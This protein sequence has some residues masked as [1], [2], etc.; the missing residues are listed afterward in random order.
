MACVC[1]CFFNFPL[2]PM[3]ET[4]LP[5]TKGP[6]S[7][8]RAECVGVGSGG[9]DRLLRRFARA[10]F[11]LSRQNFPKN[12]TL[13]Y[14]AKQGGFFVI[15]ISWFGFTVRIAVNLYVYTMRSRVHYRRRVVKWIGECRSFFFSSK[16]LFCL[17]IL[18]RKYT[19][20]LYDSSP[21]GSMLISYWERACDHS[22]LRFSLAALFCQRFFVF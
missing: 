8:W 22:F 1:V 3:F 6:E 19:L 21:R 4:R 14:T 7:I 10:A 11:M 17:L 12:T 13:L 5:F 20:K 2:H 18:S 9:E 16:W 15:I